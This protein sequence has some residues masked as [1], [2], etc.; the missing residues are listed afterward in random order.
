MTWAVAV[1]EVG[2]PSGTQAEVL[3]GGGGDR[4]GLSGPVP[5]PAGSICWWMP[6]MVAVVGWVGP[7][8]NSSG[9]CSGATCS[10]LGWGHSLGLWSYFLLSVLNPTLTVYTEFFFNFYLE[11]ILDY[12]KVAKAAQSSCILLI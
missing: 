5:R 12:R 6:S 2:Q 4:D 10:G 8:S 9:E 1:A 7:T 3:T 11:I